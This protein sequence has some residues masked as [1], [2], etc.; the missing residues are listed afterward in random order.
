MH[1]T[2]EEEALAADGTE[3]ERLSMRKIGRAHV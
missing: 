3:A 2:R 1:L